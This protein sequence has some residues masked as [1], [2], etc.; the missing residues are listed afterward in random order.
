MN[1]KKQIKLNGR[2]SDK[3]FIIDESDLNVVSKYKWYLRGDG[4][5][6]ANIKR[7][8]VYI[9]RFIMDAPKGISIDHKDRDKLNNSKE[10]LRMCAHS[11]NMDYYAKSKG[12]KGSIKKQVSKNSVYW[13]GEVRSNHQ[14]YITTTCETEEQAK[15]ALKQLIKDFNL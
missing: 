15:G 10:N 8:T 5:V 7:K 14:R 9:H 12:R 1:S 4:Y 11:E 3:H 6:A 2:H 13:Y